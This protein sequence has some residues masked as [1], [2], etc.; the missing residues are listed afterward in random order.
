MKLYRIRKRNKR[1]SRSTLQAQKGRIYK[2]ATTKLLYSNY[3]LIHYLFSLFNI[4]KCFSSFRIQPILI[5]KSIKHQFICPPFSKKISER[6]PGFYKSICSCIPDQTGQFHHF[7]KF[8][9]LHDPFLHC[10][11]FSIFLCLCK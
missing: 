2:K 6:F 7:V 1:K 9:H 10:G 4:T 8:R 3:K 5:S 11:C